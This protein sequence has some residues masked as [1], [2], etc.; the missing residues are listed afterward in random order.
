MKTTNEVWDTHFVGVIIFSLYFLTDKCIYTFSLYLN[1]V[2]VYLICHAVS[3]LP[4]VQIEFHRSSSSFSSTGTQS[5]RILILL[6]ICQ[7]Q[8][9]SSDKGVEPDFC[10]MAEICQWPCIPLTEINK[11]L[12]LFN[13]NENRDI[14]N[15]TSLIYFKA[16]LSMV[17]IYEIIFFL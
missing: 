15:N 8:R 1:M 5:T 9:S 10:L 11:K 7:V 17:L 6:C 4:V 12:K 16:A 14:N 3:P 13:I 2:V